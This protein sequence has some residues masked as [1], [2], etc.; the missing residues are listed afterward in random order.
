MF[1]PYELR[2]RG[3]TYQ[4]PANRMLGAI[5]SAEEVITLA[6]LAR[7]MQQS[8]PPLTRIA[9]A[10]G[11][12]LRYAGAKVTDEEVYIGMFEDPGADVLA[13]AS[14]LLALM[15]PPNAA[16]RAQ[17]KG[18]EGPFARGPADPLAA[19]ALH[20]AQA[21]GWASSPQATRPSSPAAAGSRPRPSGA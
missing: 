15:V 18:G 4:I 9:R 8:A 6:E 1:E 5:A 11:A 21:G 7:A 14:G 2:W 20:E 16:E 10:Y 3:T 17:R 12:V 13:A 19:A